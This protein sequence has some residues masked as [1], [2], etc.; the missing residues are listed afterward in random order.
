[1]IHLFRIL[2]RWNRRYCNTKILALCCCVAF[3]FYGLS[4]EHAL[5]LRGGYFAFPFGGTKTSNLELS[6]QFRPTEKGRLEFNIGAWQDKGSAPSEYQVSG[7]C[8]YQWVWEF[9]TGFSWSVGVGFSAGYH[10]HFYYD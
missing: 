3:S 2:N 5:G 4:Q 7:S 8:F 10:N 9:G 6:Y 1:M